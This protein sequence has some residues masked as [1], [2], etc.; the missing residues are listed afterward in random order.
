MENILLLSKSP[1]LLQVSTGAEAR[2][3]SAGNDESA[4][5][6]ELGIVLLDI[7]VLLAIGAVLVLDVGDL[8]AQGG[9]E[10]LG[11]GV[12]GL[13]PIE[14]EDADVAGVGGGDVGDCDDGAGGVGGVEA[15]EEGGGVIVD[16]RRWHYG[17]GRRAEEE[18]RR[19][20]ERV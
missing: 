7:W 8:R 12:A 20:F 6:A 3:D 5:G 15:A 1:T 2:V 10:V 14:L 18:T 13:G 11:D 16:G 9:E 19:H 17:A 4:R